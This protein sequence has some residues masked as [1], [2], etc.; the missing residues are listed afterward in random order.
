ME[1]SRTH[2]M[3]YK[4]IVVKVGS[5]VVTTGD[6]YPDIEQIKNL[7]EQLA[8]VK[9]KGLQVV[10]VSSGAVACGR[11]VIRINKKTDEVALRQQ[12]AAVGQI[13]L[14]SQY[15]HLL[16][17]HG[18]VCAQ[19]LVTRAD[20]RDRRH[21]LNMKN[22]VTHLL[23]NQVLPVVNENDVVAVTE[24]MFTDNDELSGLI[25]AMI[26][27]DALILLTSVDGLYY[28]N[29]QDIGAKV[30]PEVHSTMDLSF[31][32]PGKSQFGRGGMITKVRMARQL[33][34]IGIAVH[35]ANGRKEHILSR[36][37][38]GVP[39]GTR[40][41]PQKTTSALKRWVAHSG[42][43]TKGSVVINE[44]AEAALTA[45]SRAASLL[46]VGIVKVEGQFEKGDIIRILSQSGKLLGLGMARYSSEKAAERM[47]LKGQ[48]EL[49]H[50]DYLF[51]N[52]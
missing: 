16:A 26:Q 2:L 43:F 9:K 41:V 25:A 8:W 48:P 49:V 46:P 20:F 33:S 22:C 36:I 23:R 19:V 13:K 14:I 32:S 31:V 6:G 17:G 52:P 39:E 7:T 12:L 4:T 38:H 3:P 11:S 34:R 30:I 44:G 5:N 42:G 40:F 50:Y 35:I 29:P 10:L 18:I 24:L 27:A 1:K 21:Y 51:L 15:A 37:L 28:G 47:G 45:T